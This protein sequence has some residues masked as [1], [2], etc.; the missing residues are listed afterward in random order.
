MGLF[1]KVQQEMIMASAKKSQQLAEPKKSVSSKSIKANLDQISHNVIEYFKDSK[2]ELI[3]S[4]EQLHDYVTQMIEFGIGGIDT[5]TTG[6]DRLKD[7]IVGFSLYFPNNVEVYI[8]CKH[9]VPIFDDQYPNQISYEDI[10][11]ELQRFVDA[12]TK[13]VFANADF[14]LAMIYKDF[15]VDLIDNCYYDVIIAWRCLK[16]NERDNSLKGLYNKY[17]LKGKG[18]PMKFRDFFSPELFPYC[19]PEVAKLY[20]ANDAKITYELFLWQLPYVTKDN[21]KCKKH[22]FDAIA[23]LVWG[24]EFPMIAVCQRMH[25]RGIYLEQSVGDMLKRKYI[26]QC[27]EEHKKLRQMV[28]ELVDDPKY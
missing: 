4:V 16:E 7:W 21:P 2:A 15:K 6:L 22:N 5:E 17:P 3:T 8:P 1:S 20:A 10:G 12:G 19:K 9:I 13:L 24:V 14:D 23:D 25:R 26:P 28:Q 18:D 27:D 11:R